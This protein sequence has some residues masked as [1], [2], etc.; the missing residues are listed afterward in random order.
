MKKILLILLF[1]NAL[2]LQAQNTNDKRISNNLSF[3]YSYQYTDFSFDNIGSKYLENMQQTYGNSFN[4]R[5]QFYPILIDASAFAS[6]FNLFYAND[7]EYIVH[8]GAGFSVSYILPVNK[9]S[10]KIFPYIGVGY[11]Y[12]TLWGDE[13]GDL[14]S[15]FWKA[16]AIVNFN[17]YIYLNLEYRASAK[18]KMSYPFNQFSVGIGMRGKPLYKTLKFIGKAV[19]LVGVVFLDYY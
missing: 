15:P 13:Y 1:A 4:L 19:L 14:K 11:Q 7:Y 17:Q 18:Y 6:Y 5:Y 3:H 8:S 16:G 12:S 9:K 10:D 2:Q